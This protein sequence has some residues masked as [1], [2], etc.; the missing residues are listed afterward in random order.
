MLGFAHYLRTWKRVQGAKLTKCASRRQAKCALKSAPD[1][2]VRTMLTPDC[3]KPTLFHTA[4]CGLEELFSTVL[5]M[6]LKPIHAL[7]V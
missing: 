2:L 1:R 4:A 7:R 3:I 6:L 5:E